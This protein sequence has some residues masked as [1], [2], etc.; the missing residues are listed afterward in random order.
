MKAYAVAIALLLVIFGSIGGYL[1]KRFSAFAS[2][3]FSPPPVT[4]AASVATLETWSDTLNAVG[5]IQSVRGVELTSEGSGEIIE[6]R[7]ASGDHVSG[8]P[9]PGGVEQQGG[10][11]ESAQSGRCAG[12]GRV[13]VS[14]A[15][16]R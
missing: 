9:A 12:A 15:I 3:D 5:T 1:Y 8:R 10:A 7:F 4:I 6:I 14:S 11:G 16:D 2:T 13:V